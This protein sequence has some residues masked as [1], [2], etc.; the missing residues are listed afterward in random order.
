MKKDKNRL[1]QFLDI[2]EINRKQFLLAP[3]E[4]LEDFYFSE[5]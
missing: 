1:K 2:E 5:S 3:N 4:Y